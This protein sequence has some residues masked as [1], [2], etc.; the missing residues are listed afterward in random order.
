[1]VLKEFPQPPKD[2]P[3]QTQPG[4]S[5]KE[6]L[7]FIITIN[8]KTSHIHATDCV[9]VFVCVCVCVWMY[10]YVCVYLCVCVGGVCIIIYVCVC[11]C[12]CVVGSNTEE[13]SEHSIMK[14]ICKK[15]FV[16]SRSTKML[17]DW[18]RDWLW[19]WPDSSPGPSFISSASY[20]LLADP[21]LSLSLPPPCSCSFTAKQW[22]AGSC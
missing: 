7:D 6:W 8:K 13:T 9:S 20:I 21:S 12:V 10:L 14:C 16:K 15:W 22:T 4:I 5:I 1:M 19:E 11:V 3:L 18:V 17:L 2:N